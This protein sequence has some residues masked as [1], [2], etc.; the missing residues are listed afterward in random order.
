M[1]VLKAPECL[2]LIPEAILRKHHAYRPY[3]TRFQAA[4]RLG[5]A[6]WREREHLPIGR[7]PRGEQSVKWGNLLG[8]AAARAGANFLNDDIRTVV[9]R[10]LAY[11]EPGAMID[12]QRLWSNLM[13]SMPLAFNLFA[14]MKHDRALAKRVMARLAPGLF[15][16][17]SLVL[18]EHSPSRGDATLTDD[19]TAYDVFITGRAADGAKVF[20]AIEV[21]FTEAATEPEARWRKRYDTL[22]EQCG[23]FREPGHEALRRNPLQQFWRLSML[24][25]ASVDCGAYDRGVVLVVAPKRNRQVQRATWRFE[26]LLTKDP[27]KVGF[28]SVTLEDFVD[29]LRQ[30]GARDHAAA[31]ADRY[32]DFGSVHALVLDHCAS[33]STVEALTTPCT[34]NADKAVGLNL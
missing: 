4:A 31:L 9:R 8:P 22:S 19:G 27:A 29:V 6:L 20:A 34:A 24:A 13:S 32:L 30:A 7:L 16:S 28:S 14:P 23:L 26:R 21:K 18:F 3:D 10:E 25:Q 17:I 11:R 1:T 12:E 33:K 5:Q 2:P 15:K